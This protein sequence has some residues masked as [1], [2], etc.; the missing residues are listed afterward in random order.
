[1]GTAAQRELDS[2]YQALQA[3]GYS[4]FAI[5]VTPAAS[6]F[7]GSNVFRVKL[8]N[9]VIATELALKQYP[10][11]QPVHTSLATIHTWMEQARSNGIT[12]IPTVQRTLTQQSFH[13]MDGHS[14][15][16]HSWMPGQPA[17]DPSAEQ[18]QQA[19]QQ[20]HR[21]HQTWRRLHPP[22]SAPCPAV[23]LQYQR[24]IE[25]RTEE[26]DQLRRQGSPIATQA[27]LF[28]QGRIPQAIH[29]LQPWLNRKVLVQPCLADIWADHLLFEQNKLTGL[30][31]FGG[32]RL[33]HP[34][35]DLAR[36]ISS[37]SLTA[38]RPLDK[39]LLEYPDQSDS[40]QSLSNMLAQ[41]GLIVS[42]SNWLRWL[43]LE[44]RSFANR[45]RCLQ[46]MQQIYVRLCNHHHKLL[47]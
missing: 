15:E 10:L 24:L 19:V 17:S 2:A 33:D 28:L 41:T 37:W 12:I 3:F 26:W 9:E 47:G 25:W 6:G 39:C 34:A 40:F 13:V 45:A 4:R 36:L 30:I 18:L 7:S 38:S 21:L 32:A 44:Q 42:L 20:L 35:Q 5:E 31:D 8:K 11:D 46:R 22:I 14:W 27:A 23:Q 43:F 16:L 29:T 1:M